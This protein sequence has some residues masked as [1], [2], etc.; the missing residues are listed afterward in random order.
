[1]NYKA[2]VIYCPSFCD[3]DYKKLTSALA[4]AQEDLFFRQ[5]NSV[6]LLLPVFERENFTNRHKEATS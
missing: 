6:G 1:M 5:I 3:E 2:E 4:T